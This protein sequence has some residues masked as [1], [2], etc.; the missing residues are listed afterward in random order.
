MTRK[1]SEIISDFLQLVEESQSKYNFN[2]EQVN[3]QDLLKT[4]IEHK[5]ELGKPDAKER[6]KLTKLLIK[7]LQERREYKDAAEQACVMC[8][9]AEKN[10]NV[11]KTLREALGQMKKLE[12]Y[13]ENRTYVPR[14][15]KDW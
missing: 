3:K 13:H 6:T 11:M 5:L 1:N 14:V 9:F 12:N 2:Y 7:C 4:D 8:D 15:M 10:K